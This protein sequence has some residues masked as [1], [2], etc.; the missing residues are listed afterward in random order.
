MLTKRLV[1][2]RS[3]PGAPLFPINHEIRG[4]GERLA[5]A[6]AKGRRPSTVQRILKAAETIFAERGLA[7]RGPARLPGPPALTRRC[8]ITISA[9][10][11]DIHRFTLE[12]V[13]SQ[14]R[15][16]AGAASRAPDRRR[17]AARLCQRLF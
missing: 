14:L 1:K 13:F 10:K 17:A 5:A 16:Q 11:E 2:M 8:S 15:S 12:M 6:W 4:G 9:I 3:V 7:G